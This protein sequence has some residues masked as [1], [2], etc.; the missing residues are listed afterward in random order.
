MQIS[1]FSF[2]DSFF[3]I[4]CLTCRVYIKHSDREQLSEQALSLCIQSLK[5]QIK[6][7]NSTSALQRLVLD[8]FRSYQRIQKYIPQKETIFSGMLGDAY[9]KFMKEKIPE[10]VNVLDLAIKFCQQHK[11]AE[12][13]KQ[14]QQKQTITPP[15]APII[16]GTASFNI[17]FFR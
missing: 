8:L 14:Q 16:S 6:N 1:K 17:I 7:L 5:A 12:K 10:N 11:A 3:I 15:A 4:K 9:K 13:L 2:R